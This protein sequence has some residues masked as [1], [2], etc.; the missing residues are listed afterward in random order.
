MVDAVCEKSLI[1]DLVHTS[2]LSRK[3]PTSVLHLCWQIALVVLVTLI[4]VG[5]VFGLTLYFGLQS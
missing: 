1:L 4:F 2:F 5:L 3:Q